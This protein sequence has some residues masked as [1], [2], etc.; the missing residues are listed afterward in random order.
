[1]AIK[2]RATPVRAQ[3]ALLGVTP[4][5]ANERFPPA[6][7]GSF[8]PR[9]RTC[10]R[11]TAYGVDQP[12]RPIPPALLGGASR[13][14]AADRPISGSPRRRSVSGSRREG[15]AIEHA[16]PVLDELDT[17]VEGAVVDHVE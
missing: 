6:A 1:M 11:S 13:T 7:F 4:V 17:A 8:K 16:R 3:G 12:D 5:N 15:W 14:P 10:P 9:G 2:L